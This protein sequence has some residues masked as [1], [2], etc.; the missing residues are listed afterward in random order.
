MVVVVAVVVSIIGSEKKIDLFNFF[1]N[2]N[3]KMSGGVW[4]RLYNGSRYVGMCELGVCDE[5]TVLYQS[6]QPLP[7]FLSTLNLKINPNLPL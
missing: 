7:Q 6:E 4:I 5:L 1:R 2:I 3:I